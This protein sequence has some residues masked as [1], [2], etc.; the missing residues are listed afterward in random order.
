M[1]MLVA[2]K[3]DKL[4]G[5]SS[6]LIGEWEWTYS[7]YFFSQCDP[8]AS[9]KTIDPDSEEV[10]YSMKF[11]EKGIVEFYRDG[12]LIDKHRVVVE[13]FEIGFCFADTKFDFTIYPDNDKDNY[14]SGCI[15]ND[16][17]VIGMGFPYYDHEDGCYNYTNY[18]DR[19]E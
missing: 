1:L 13:Q 2:C 19:V 10:N 18:F 14:I 9:F 15:G 11:H 16:K 17:V 3:K 8:P 4:E 6:I 5:D 12:N 7:D